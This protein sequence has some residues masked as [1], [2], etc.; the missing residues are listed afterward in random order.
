M[1]VERKIEKNLIEKIARGDE[2]AFEEIYRLYRNRVYGFIYR[3][4]VNQTVAEDI[5]HETFLV[6]IKHPERFR[7]ERGSILTFLCAIARNLLINNLRRKNNS[8]V[9]FD[10]FEDFD[11]P[12]DE[13]KTNPLTGLLNQELAARIEMCIGA[14]PPLQREA[15]ILR[16]YQELSYEEIATI[17]ETEISAVKSRL[18]RARQNLARELSQYLTSPKKKHYELR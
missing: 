14:L 15:I 6:L 13:L 5:T 18:H 4:T 16:E 2:I 9:G 12:E 8:D 10:E 3:M 1:G 11:V 7:A 17:T